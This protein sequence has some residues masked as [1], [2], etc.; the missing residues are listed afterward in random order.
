MLQPNYRGSTGF[1]ADFVKAGS[2]QWGRGMQDDIDDAVKWAA[3]QGIADSKRVCIMGASF[4]GYAALWASVRN[5]DIYRCAI[6]FAGISDVGAMLRYDQGS[7]AATKYFR[8][9]RSRVQGD[10]KF[11]LKQISPLYSA[12]K[13][14]IPLLIAHGTADDNVPPVQS[15]QFHDALLKAGKPHDYILYKDEGHGFRKDADETDFLDR[16]ARFLDKNNPA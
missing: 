7:F 11:D 4:G 16:V 10:A 2:G 8:S 1:G 5:P 14:S 6:S 3:A 15:R 13:M 12:D 9:W